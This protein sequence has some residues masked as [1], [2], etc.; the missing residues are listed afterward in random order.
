MSEARFS[1]G[2]LWQDTPGAFKGAVAVAVVAWFVSLSTATTSMV[3]G[4]IASCDYFDIVKVAGAVVIVALVIAGF[5]ANAKS[6]RPLPLPI[7]SVIAVVL[8]AC[9]VLLAIRGFGVALSPCQSANP[10]G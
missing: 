3:N 6:A 4:V 2:R 10:I 9:A 5:L 1:K 7:V 8:L